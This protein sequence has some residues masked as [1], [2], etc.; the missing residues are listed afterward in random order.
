MFGFYAGVVQ[1]GLEFPIEIFTSK[2]KT[3]LTIQEKEPTVITIDNKKITDSFRRLFQ[4]MWKDG[5]R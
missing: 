5:E 1:S 3:F 4:V 2:D